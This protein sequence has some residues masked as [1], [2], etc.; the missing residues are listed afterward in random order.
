MKL[1]SLFILLSF[2][3]CTKN[4]LGGQIEYKR[5]GSG[6]AA[7]PS[8]A[9]APSPS[10]SVGNATGFK[11]SPG[12]DRM[13]GSDVAATGTVLFND[14]KLSGASV[15]GKFSLQKTNVR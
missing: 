5:I 11:V 1:I 3:A 13:A 6:S 14:R 12:V 9:P 15:G 10:P 7:S 4:P 8:P 2:I